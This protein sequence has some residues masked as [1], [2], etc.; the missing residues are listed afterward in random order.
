[1]GKSIR[2]WT[3]VREF[4][5]EKVSQE[6]YIRNDSI[7]RVSIMENSDKTISVLVH[8]LGSTYLATVSET[9]Q[10]AHRQLE[11]LAQGINEAHA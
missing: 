6:S 7:Q 10:E 8:A 2:G 3:L 5:T 9:L 4:P 1:M 11:H